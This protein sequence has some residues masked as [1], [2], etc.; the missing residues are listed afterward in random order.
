M[1]RALYPWLEPLWTRL[2]ATDEDSR[3][4]ALLLSGVTGLGKQAVAM[5]LARAWLCAGDSRP[6]GECRACALLSANSHPDLHVLSTEAVCAGRQDQFAA[7]ARRYF[8]EPGRRKKPSRV[9]PVDAIRAMGAQLAQTGHQSARR[10][11][12]VWPADAMNANAA[13]SLLKLL[14]E[15][16]V[17]A[18][19]LLVSDHP[20]SLPATIRSRCLPQP[21]PVPPEQGASDWLVEQGIAADQAGLLLRLAGG[22][23]LRALALAGEGWLA[24]R[25]QLLEDVARFAAGRGDPVAAARR[26]KEIGT[27]ESLRWLHGWSVDLLRKAHATGAAPLFNPDCDSALEDQVKRLNLS[28]LHEIFNVI[29]ESISGLA[30][31]LD[32]TLMLEDILARWRRVY[33]GV[34]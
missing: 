7:F 14:E 6:C 16:P 15:P 4:Q 23:P 28:R 17:G 34:T 1:S 26:W 11:V 10:V 8:P 13:N 22:G 20:A 24:Q 19:F 27:S 33:S 21:V 32:E 18:H 29:S 3:P 12:L 9:I 2:A 5:E 31:N 30:G 25:Q